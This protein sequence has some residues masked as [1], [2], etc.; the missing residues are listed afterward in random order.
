MPL[1]GEEFG[2]KGYALALVIDLLC[3]PL[4]G[5]PF[6]SQIP[7]MFADLDAPRRLGAWSLSDKCAVRL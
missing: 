4:N 7:P 3:G 5:N 1:G 6:G 2:Y